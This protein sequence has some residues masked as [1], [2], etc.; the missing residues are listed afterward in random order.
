MLIRTVCCASLLGL[1]V[2]HAQE[3]PE[4]KLYIREFRLLSVREVPA[5][6]VQEAVYPFLGPARTLE[7]IENARLA[8]ERL[9][10]AR[11]FEAA[12]VEIP[13]QR[14]RGG[15][16][17][18][19]VHEGRIGKLRV[20]G[21]RYFSPEDIKRHAHSLGEGVAINFNDVNRDIVA[22]N[23]L[24]DRRV[25]P[26]L[27]A[28][29]V[30]GTVDVDLEVKDTFPLHGSLEL[31]NRYSMDTS[32]L[33]LN[34]SLSYGNLWQRGHTIGA[35]LQVS[36]EKQD[37]VQVFSGFYLMRYPSWGNVS[38]LLQG[39]KQD[40][41]VSTLGSVAVAGKG[42]TL[43]ARLILALPPLKGFVHNVSF[44][45]D[46]KHYNNGVTMAGEL[47]EAPLTYYPF[48]LSYN[49]MRVDDGGMM[50]FNANLIW[51]IR[52]FGSRANKYEL[53]RSGSDG[54]FIYLRADASRN[55]KLPYG[56]EL[57]G[58]VQGQLAGQPLVS[59]EQYGGG[60]LGTVRGYLEAEVVGDNAAFGSLELRSPELLGWLPW[61]GNSL[62][63]YLFGEGGVVS[64][65]NPLP[66]Q[67]SRFELASVGIGARIQIYDYLNGS[68]DAAIPLTDQV[69][70]RS[71]HP[72]LTFRVWA[73]F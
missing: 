38:L 51:S 44:G 22:L 24:A 28:G 41:N 55:Q 3:A 62:Q 5:L 30:P 40:S 65:H 26:K 20:T 52:D 27:K 14:G 70:T 35:S 68:L 4:R 54:N 7:D 67:Q 37:E 49:A 10:H 6:D 57:H 63:L 34:A 43:G 31:N 72:F 61:K 59:N 32:P 8:V 2:S 48:A 12:S 16:I 66:E 29:E 25:T 69:E 21:A 71:G 45:I 39:S 17:V 50:E 19:K 53:N 11:G 13:A 56:F 15:V 46:Y 42:E 1:S 33:R 23:Q 58:K 64:L 9:Y 73:D 18:L 60:G 36:P 47:S